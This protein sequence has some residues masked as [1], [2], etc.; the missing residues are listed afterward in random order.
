MK[1][2]RATLLININDSGSIDR[3]CY[4]DNCQSRP[5]RS[6]I[7]REIT[8]ALSQQLKFLKLFRDFINHSVKLDRIE[9]ET[10]RKKEGGN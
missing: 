8:G 2:S 6:E 4:F 3:H 10:A 7:V 5:L 1:S 9:A